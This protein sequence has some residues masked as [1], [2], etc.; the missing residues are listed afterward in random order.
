MY[1]LHEVSKEEVKLLLAT[2]KKMAPTRKV[3]EDEAKSSMCHVQKAVCTPSF[4]AFHR[5]RSMRRCGQLWGWLVLVSARP[6]VVAMDSASHE[7]WL[8]ET[9]GG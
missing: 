4:L 9:G 8:P 5:S 1:V 6:F 7:P 3:R 2:E